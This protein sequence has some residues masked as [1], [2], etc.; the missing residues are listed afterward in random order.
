MAYGS[1]LKS[2]LC[3]FDSHQGHQNKHK[4]NEVDTE[5]ITIFEI[6]NL[7]DNKD[8]LELEKIFWNLL[9]QDKI[10]WSICIGPQDFFGYIVKPGGDRIFDSM[11]VRVV[12]ASFSIEASLSNIATFTLT[13]EQYNKIKNAVERYVVCKAVTTL[14]SWFPNMA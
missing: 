8:R 12:P 13:P 5:N 10:D 2:E 7:L 4:D 3:G 1:D 6:M 9:D 11:V 14:H